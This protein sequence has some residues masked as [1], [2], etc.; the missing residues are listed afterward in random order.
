MTSMYAVQR[1][2]DTKVTVNSGICS[3]G[4]MRAKDIQP[5]EFDIFFRIECMWAW[6]WSREATTAHIHYAAHHRIIAVTLLRITQD[7]IRA[8]DALHL[9]SPFR[10]GD[11]RMITPGE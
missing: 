11:V 3:E 8:V 4:T 2:D 5:R 9:N 6:L 7:S 10:S 1:G